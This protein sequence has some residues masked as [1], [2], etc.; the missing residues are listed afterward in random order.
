MPVLKAA[1]RLLE[2]IFSTATNVNEFQR[3]VTVPNVLKLTSAL[4]SLADNRNE[5]GLKV[6][7]SCL[8]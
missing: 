8:I 5:P 3:Q 4:L 2:V 7:I 1:I 6:R